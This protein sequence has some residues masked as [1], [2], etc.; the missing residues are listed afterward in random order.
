MIGSSIWIMRAMIQH[1]GP[2]HCFATFRHDSYVQSGEISTSTHFDI[3][4]VQEQCQDADTFRAIY[5]VTN[6]VV[7]S[8]KRKE[9]LCEH[10]TNPHRSPLLLHV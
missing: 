3:V 5:L 9:R 8:L 2:E 6:I 10:P 1:T 4:Q 7:V